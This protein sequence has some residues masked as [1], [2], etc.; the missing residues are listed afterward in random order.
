MSREATAQ[1]LAR[2][3]TQGSDCVLTGR[4]A[5]AGKTGCVL[6]FV[7]KLRSEDIP[8]LAFRLDRLD[9]VS[10]TIELGQRLGLDESPALVLAAAAAKGNAVLVIDQLDAI[11]TTSGRTTGFLDAVEALLNEARGLRPRSQIHVVVVCREFDWK[12]DH[13]LRKLLPTEH[14]HVAVG[15]FSNDEVNSVLQAAR[16]DVTN[17]SRGKS[18]CSVYLKTSL[19]SWRQS[20]LLRHPSVPRWICLIDIGT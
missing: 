7:E 18:S 11:S 10:T 8:V 14:N 4:R 6:E 19:S 9:P 12:N 13:R 3:D 15:E 17:C 2:L 20:S 16:F 1:L 5:G